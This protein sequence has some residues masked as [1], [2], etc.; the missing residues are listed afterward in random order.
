MEVSDYGWMRRRVNAN[1]ESK[2]SKLY[3]CPEREMRRY[4]RR[5][6]YDYLK[7]LRRHNAN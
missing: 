7:M 6:D 3:K 5:D 4:A 2:G 1:E